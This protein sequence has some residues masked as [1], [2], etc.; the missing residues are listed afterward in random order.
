[1]GVI[2]EMIRLHAYF[3]GRVQGVGFRYRTHSLA[4]G[5]P[6]TG[7]VRNLPDGRVELVAEGERAELEEF[8]ACVCAEMGPGID[9]EKVSWEKATGEFASFGISG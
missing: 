2:A 4:E 7:W 1:M 5:R 3:S 8:L 9:E 6:V